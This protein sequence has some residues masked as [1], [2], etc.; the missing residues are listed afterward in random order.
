MK[1]PT[2]P[3][4]QVCQGIK[5]SAALLGEQAGP[6]LMDMVSNLAQ[7]LLSKSVVNEETL[8]ETANINIYTKMTLGR[9]LG[10][11]HILARTADP[12]WVQFPNNFCLDSLKNNTCES[13][14]GIA[15]IVYETNPMATLPTSPR[16]APNTQVIDLTVSNRANR[17]VDIKGNLCLIILIIYPDFC[18][19]NLNSFIKIPNFFHFRCCGY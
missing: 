15:A 1:I 16:L 7:L 14:A 19:Q 12:P 4:T 11:R 9:D 10:K 17:I 18:F 6:Q 5:D 8:I 13:A 2:D 3:E